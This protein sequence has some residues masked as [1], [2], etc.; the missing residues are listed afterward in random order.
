MFSLKPA[1]DF[2]LQRYYKL[3]SVVSAVY[4]GILKRYTG[5][6]WVKEPLKTYLAAVWATKPLKR[7]DGA[8]WKTVDTTGV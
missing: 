2:K 4:Y 7:Y 5:V 1:D 6:T 8:T 3:S